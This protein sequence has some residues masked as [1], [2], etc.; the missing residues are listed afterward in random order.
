[1]DVMR[2]GDKV[3][4]KRKISSII[5]KALHLR[6]EGLS[7]QEVA[8]MMGLDRPFISRLEKLGE[9]RKG[10][11]IGVVA[12]P[13]E[14]KLELE[15][16]LKEEG[17]DFMLLMTDEER[18]SFVKEKQ[19]IELFNEVMDIISRLRSCD[20]IIVIGSNYRIKL[21]EALV[22]KEVIGVEIGKS[23]IECDKLIDMKII[24][25]IFSTMNL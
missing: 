25:N 12:F 1:M 16:Y 5:E 8:N 22:D 18:W 24:Q 6:S 15:Q 7:Q 20:V 23:P 11:K 9:I 21:C 13:I 2:I 14:N 19:G 17:V 4:S 10:R 3:L